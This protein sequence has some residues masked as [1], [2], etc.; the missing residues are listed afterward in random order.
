MRGF[1]RRCFFLSFRTPSPQPSPLRGEGGKL[2]VIALRP[3]LSRRG[4]WGASGRN[5]STRSNQDAEHDKDC[6]LGRIRS[7]CHAHG[8]G[9]VGRDRAS[10][11]RTCGD[12]Q[13]RPRHHQRCV[14]AGRPALPHAPGWLVTL[15]SVGW[16]EPLR[17]PSPARANLMGFAELVIGPA[18]QAGPVGPTHPTRSLTIRDSWRRDS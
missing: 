17:N 14:S 9:G 4:R 16:V 7:Q 12:L 15:E 2:G 6:A 18:L 5:G 10:R 3:Y 13:R 11:A 1:G 8:V